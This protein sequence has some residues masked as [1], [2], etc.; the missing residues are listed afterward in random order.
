MPSNI[1]QNNID[2][3]YPVAGADNDSQGFRTNF[4][5][6]RNNLGFAKQE[7]E[8]LQ[9]K[10]ILKSALTGTT[11]NNNFGGVVVSSAQ[12]RDFREIR[13]DLG[14]GNG[15]FNLDHRQAH[16]YTLITN[17][18]ISLS[19]LGFPTV[20]QAGHIKF[21]LTVTNTAHTMTLPATVSR[22]TAGISGL[23]VSTNVLTFAETGTYM[24]EFWSDDAG[25]VIHMWEYSR[26]RSGFSS[27][28]IKLLQRT[29]TNVG[30]PGDEP[31]MIAVDSSNMFI[32]TGV[33]DGSTAIWLRSTFTSY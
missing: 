20:G 29:P 13:I 30:Q 6:I 7:L 4:T 23:N 26:P 15:T 16:S 28:E 1:N 2:S 11:L 9:N 24:F 5:N 22:G 25:T 27:T 31:G 12:I 18:S 8:D 14:T 17:G 32:C 10:V 21:E 33:Y 3:T 19:F